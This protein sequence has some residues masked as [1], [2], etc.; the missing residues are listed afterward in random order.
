MR[1]IV[2]L[3]LSLVPLIASAQTDTVP[4]QVAPPKRGAEVKVTTRSGHT[5]RGNL[6]GITPDSVRINTPAGW[7]GRWSRLAIPRDSVARLELMQRGP[8]HAVLGAALGLA[9]GATAGVL[10]ATLNCAAFCSPQDDHKSSQ[11]FVAALI[12]GGVLGALV[13][14]AIRS[15]SSSE[16]PLGPTTVTIAPVGKRVGFGLSLRF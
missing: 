5:Y 3:F 15:D 6:D 16:V 14:S 12:G 1:Y 4:S 7:D 11:I 9:V 2:P 13:G 8:G 10:G